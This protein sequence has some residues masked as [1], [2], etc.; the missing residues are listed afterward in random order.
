MGEGGGVRPAQNHAV[1][2]LDITG[3]VIGWPSG[4]LPPGG[5]DTP[6][7]LSAF[8][9][10]DDR[11]IGLPARDLRLAADGGLQVE[12]WRLRSN[13]SRFWATVV[14]TPICDEVGQ[15]LGIVL[16]LSNEIAVPR[17]GNT[18][19]GLLPTKFDRRKR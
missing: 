4:P 2:L 9:T 12:A 7:H 17:V 13:G 16:V 14:M 15:V 3:R 5:E 8:Y 1:Y 19:G 10:P 6:S 18:Q 11:L